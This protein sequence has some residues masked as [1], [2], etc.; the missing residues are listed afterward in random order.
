[1]PPVSAPPRRFALWDFPLA[2]GGLLP[3]ASLDYR[4][5]GTLAEDRSNLVLYPSSYGAWP[6]DI[7]WVVGPILDPE[8]WCVVLVSQ[9][10]NGRSS[11]PS[12]GDPGLAGGRWPVDH[13]DNV[14]AQRR[15]L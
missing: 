9:F 15:L 10:G 6:E 1:M 2:G 7:D 11:S 13:R 14:A 3:A 12:T 8:R 4:V 5:Y